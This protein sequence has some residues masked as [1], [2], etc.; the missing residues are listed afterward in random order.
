VL[1]LAISETTLWGAWGGET[2]ETCGSDRTG[3]T[4]GSDRTGETCG[5]DRI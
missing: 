4:C 5:G 2:G 1:L 3:E